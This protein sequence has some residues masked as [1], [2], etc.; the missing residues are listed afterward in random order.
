MKVKELVTRLIDEPMEAEVC[1]QDLTEHKSNGTISKGYI[2][3]ITYI[4]HWN[5][6]RI[7]INFED[8]RKGADIEPEMGKW[9]KAADD[10]VWSY[11]D[12]YAECNK[13]HNVTFNGWN[14]N[15]CP[16]CG[17]YMRGGKHE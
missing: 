17:K 6:Y 4:E 10:G 5:N 7:C 16:N 12:V 9:I 1:V 8:W 13:C 14:M 3:D 2:F 11:A 15:Y